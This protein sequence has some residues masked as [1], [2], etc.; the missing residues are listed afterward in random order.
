LTVREAASFLGIAE[1]TVYD[2]VNSGQV[3]HHRIGKKR[4][5]IRFARTDLERFRDNSQREPTDVFA[6]HVKA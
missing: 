3:R 6:K 2:L 4:G 1:K 5:T